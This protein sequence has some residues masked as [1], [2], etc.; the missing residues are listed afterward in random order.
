MALFSAEKQALLLQPNGRV[1]F[2]VANICDKMC[3][4]F[5]FLQIP[6]FIL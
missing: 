1:H 4:A 6:L 2:F 3:E 5:R